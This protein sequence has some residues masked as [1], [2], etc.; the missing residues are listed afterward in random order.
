MESLHIL[1]ALDQIPDFKRWKFKPMTST[2]EGKDGKREYGVVTAESIQ[3]WAYQ[4]R[5]EEIR[6]Y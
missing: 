6:G 5:L 3:S 2:Q 1:D 4:E